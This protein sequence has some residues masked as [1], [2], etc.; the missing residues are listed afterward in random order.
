MSSKDSIS[1]VSSLRPS[2]NSDMG[3]YFHSFERNKTPVRYYL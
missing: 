1:S 3:P 2:S